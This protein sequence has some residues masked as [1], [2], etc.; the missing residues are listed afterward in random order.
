MTSKHVIGAAVVIKIPPRGV[1]AHDDVSWFSKDFFHKSRKDSVFLT[2]WS[3]QDA[4]NFRGVAR[5]AETGGLY[6]KAGRYGN[7]ATP[8][9][10]YRIV[11]G[12]KHV[13]MGVVGQ[14]SQD[15]TEKNET[16]DEARQGW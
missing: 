5:A 4:R 2:G 6:V 8:R 13:M 15:S 7:V 16:I 10:V 14:C 12:S 1:C 11:E 3:I 9:E